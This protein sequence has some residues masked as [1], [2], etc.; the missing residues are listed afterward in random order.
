[1]FKRMIQCEVSPCWLAGWLSFA[2]DTL[3]EGKR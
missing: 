2:Y 1:M 3:I